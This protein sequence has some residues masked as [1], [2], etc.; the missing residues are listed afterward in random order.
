MPWQSER[1]VREE[2]AVKIIAGLVVS[3]IVGIA[4]WASGRHFNRFMTE[5]QQDRPR[6]ECEVLYRAMYPP[7]QTVNVYHKD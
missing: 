2:G 3:L 4:I 5:C 7:S 1:E 6:Y